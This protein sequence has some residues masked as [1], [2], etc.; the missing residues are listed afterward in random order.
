MYVFFS[1]M[2]DPKM[3]NFKVWIHS[4]MTSAWWAVE[5]KYVSHC[6]LVVSFCK[7]CLIEKMAKSIGFSSHLTLADFP[8]DFFLMNDHSNYI[9]DHTKG[10]QAHFSRIEIVNM[11]NKMDANIAAEIFL[12]LGELGFGR[13]L[14][15]FL[16]K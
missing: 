9:K 15:S 8:I 7:Q 12:K 3:T 6:S 14:T 5:A 1:V 11:L 13:N 2:T 16:K 4:K 10:K